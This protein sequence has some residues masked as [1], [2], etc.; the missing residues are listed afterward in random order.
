MYEKALVAIMFM[1][2]TSFMLLA[3]QYTIADVFGLTLVNI[4]GDPVQSNIL[5]IINIS[6]FNNQTGTVLSTNQTTI[7][8]DPIIAAALM[9]LEFFQLMTG[10]Y[11]FNLMYFFGI[12]AIVTAGFSGLYAILMIRAVIAYLRGI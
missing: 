12:P 7:S 10:T 9:T 4:N 11:V 3:A 2:A 8:T 1:Y 5:E 6:E